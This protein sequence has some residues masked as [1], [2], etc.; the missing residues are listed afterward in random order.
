MHALCGKCGYYGH[1]TRSCTTHI[2]DPEG[3]S[4]P[5]K[6]ENKVVG[7]P[8][9]QQ[10]PPVTLQNSEPTQKTGETIIANNEHI[11]GIPNS[12]LNIGEPIH[13]DWLVVSRKKKPVK[14]NAKSKEKNVG[15]NDQRLANKFEL[16]SKIEKF[17]N[18]PAKKDMNDLSFYNWKGEH[19]PSRD[20]GPSKP[21]SSKT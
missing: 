11:N 7:A 12:G 14:G 10:N 13:G 3:G 15:L 2:L 9:P 16:F 17:I 21:T 19:Q 18:E 1:V 4:T 6:T 8:P 20:V 5:N